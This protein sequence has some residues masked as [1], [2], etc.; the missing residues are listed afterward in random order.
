VPVIAILFSVVRRHRDTRNGRRSHLYPD[1]PRRSYEE[2]RPI[3]DFRQ[4]N[5]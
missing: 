1:T 5:S 4:M 3:A 2:I